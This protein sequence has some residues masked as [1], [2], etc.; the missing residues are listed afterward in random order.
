MLTYTVCLFDWLWWVM[1]HESC[2]IVVLLLRNVCNWWLNW[3][4][5]AVFQWISFCC[6]LRIFW[7][8]FWPQT[9]VAW[10]FWKMSAPSRP[11][12]F[13]NCETQLLTSDQ[14]LGS[15]IFPCRPSVP[16]LHLSPLYDVLDHT[17][18]AVH[19]SS[20]G[21]LVPWSVGRS[22]T[23]NNQSLHNTTEWPQRLVTFETFD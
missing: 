2:V 6:D 18:L 5:Y 15:S 14:K 8:I 21:D 12:S 23:T 20:I 4:I 19:N 17:F 10:K 16:H 22:V 7:S 1:S 3:S 11:A 13:V 9:S